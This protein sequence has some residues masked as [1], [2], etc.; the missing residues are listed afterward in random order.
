MP[1][2]FILY[3]LF[4]VAPPPLLHPDIPGP[5][6]GPEP[7]HSLPRAQHG[8]PDG[9]G[10]QAD[11]ADHEGRGEGEEGEGEDGPGHPS[12]RAAGHWLSAGPAAG[13]K[14]GCSGKKKDIY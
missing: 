10:D 14:H 11:Q 6:A 4:Q 1:I 13:G 5:D 12:H 3:L 7:L 9:R 8:V 2:L